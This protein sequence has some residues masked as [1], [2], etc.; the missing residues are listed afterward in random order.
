M[1]KRVQIP[2]TPSQLLDLAKKVQQK[3]VADGTSSPLHVLD[4]A[5]AGPLIEKVNADHEKAEQLRREM[6][7]AFQQRQLNM[8]ELN[9]FVRSTRD[10]L[11]GKY[12]RQMKTLGQW[13]FRVLDNKVP[14]EQSPETVKQQPAKVT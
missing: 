9:D 2:V 14:V 12:R 1:K 3:H 6:H 11:A 4:W 8:A 5:V 10:V 13:G 7:E